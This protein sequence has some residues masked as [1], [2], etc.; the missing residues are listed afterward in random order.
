MK[1]LWLQGASLRT[2]AYI[3]GYKSHQ[4][5]DGAFQ[6]RFAPIKPFW[7]GNLVT[8]YDIV[9]DKFGLPKED[10]VL[11][12]ADAASGS[13]E[14]KDAARQ[15]R[16]LAASAAVDVRH[17]WM[18]RRLL[19]H[20][21]NLPIKQELIELFAPG[22]DVMVHVSPPASRRSCV[23]PLLYLSIVYLLLFMIIVGAVSSCASTG[24]HRRPL[25]RSDKWLQRR[26]R[27][28]THAP[29]AVC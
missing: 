11:K 15:A 1:Q 10:F 25:L 18:K 26:P 6:R 20:P 3:L 22:K 2:A 17:D 16:Q 4:A 28:G 24:N 21:G 29:A 5:L 12:T 23:L 7:P 13:V 9:E 27:L 19:E 14:D 8:L